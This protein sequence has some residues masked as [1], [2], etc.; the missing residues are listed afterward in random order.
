[1]PATNQ[2]PRIAELVDRLA[3]IGNKQR[4]M[5]I[6]HDE[7]NTLVDV[8]RG[9]LEVDHAQEDS[10]QQTLEQRFALAD[11]DH[12]GQVS[13]SW[14]DPSVQSSVGGGGASVSS[15]TVVADIHRQVD[16]LSSQVAQLTQALEGHQKSLD[17][18]AVSDLNRTRALSAFDARFAGIEGLRTLVTGL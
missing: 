3:P 1:M 11:H 6:E 9:I 15:R 10:A 14:L 5:P 12:L 17:Q 4:G 2:L 8:M 13:L 7:W 16:A 18:F